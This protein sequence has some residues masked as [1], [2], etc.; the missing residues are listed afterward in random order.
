MKHWKQAAGLVAAPL[1]LF[2]AACGPGGSSGSPKDASPSRVTESPAIGLLLGTSP[3][4]HDLHQARPW[5]GDATLIANAAG[6]LRAHVVIDRF[7]S[8]PGSSH[9][10]YDRRVA[11]SGLNPLIDRIQLKKAEQAMELA[12]AQES[13]STTP[14]PINLVSGVQSLAQH[15]QAFPHLTTDVVIFGDA[16]QTAAPVGLADPLQ[17]ADT[18][19]SLRSVIS[20]GLVSRGECRGW[21]VYMVG[22]SLTPGGGLSSLQDEQLREFWREFFA[23]CGG[24]LV[25][26]D[27]TLITF[28]ASGQVPPAAWTAQHKLIIPLPSSVL[29]RPNRAVFLPGARPVLDELA[30]KLTVVYPRATAVIAGFTAKTAVP[31]SGPSALALSR[32]RAR[33]VAAYLRAHGVS[34]DRLRTHGYGDRHQIPGG[35]AANRRVVVTLHIP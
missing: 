24:R 3:A 5:A 8:G 12:F 6:R 29:F 25:V 28:P 2:L 23:Y 19:E 15:L 7:G 16:V 1:T 35:L 17:L 31:G 21:Q 9:V 27:S 22:G 18:R 20:R 4:D 13:A 11:S 34:A 30:R 10:V 33:A 14:G 26:W 32:A